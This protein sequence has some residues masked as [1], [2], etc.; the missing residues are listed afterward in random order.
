[1]QKEDELIDLAKFLKGSPMNKFLGPLFAQKVPKSCHERTGLF[2]KI[3]NRPKINLVCLRSFSFRGIPSECIGIRGI[4]WRLLLGYLPPET[5]RWESFLEAKQKEYLTL[6]NQTKIPSVPRVSVRQSRPLNKDEELAKEIKTDI[7][8]TKRD[9]PFFGMLVNSSSPPT[10]EE[11]KEKPSEEDDDFVYDDT[12]THRLVLSRILYVYAKQN[13]ELEYIQGMNEL[14]SVLYY[15]FYHDSVPEMNKY[16]ESDAYFCFCNLMEELKEAY[17]RQMDK[18]FGGIQ[19]IIQ[20]IS[21]ILKRVDVEYWNYLSETKADIQLFALRWIML[22]F[23]QDMELPTVIRLWD[24][25]L[26]DPERFLFFQYVVVRVIIE[27]KKEVIGSEFY[28]FVKVIQNSPRTLKLQDLLKK[29]GNMLAKDL[30]KDSYIGEHYQ[31]Q[32]VH[33][34]I[35]I[36]L[37]LYTQMLQYC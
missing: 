3:L 34:I 36:Y 13:T 28:E 19:Q 12:E 32:L 18:T 35:S 8:R 17:S 20:K 31:L 9:I 24:S 5:A 27:A 6:Y 25:L 2:L 33:Y 1:M 4:I 10:L 23:A 30:K 16:L 26:G 14:L 7:K 37:V 11:S 21:E 15:C 22:L 29:S